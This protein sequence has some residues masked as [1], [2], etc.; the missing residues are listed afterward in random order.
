[1]FFSNA[2]SVVLN[3]KGG[4]LWNKPWGLPRISRTRKANRKKDIKIFQQNLSVLK[5]AAQLQPE[6]PVRLY[7]PLPQWQRE[8]MKRKMEEARRVMNWRGPMLPASARPLL[9]QGRQ[10]TR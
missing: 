2:L 10:Q 8:I 5:A 1:M 7:K 9:Q 3:T 6:T 4:R